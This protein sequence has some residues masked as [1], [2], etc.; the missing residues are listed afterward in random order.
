M[1]V[2]KKSLAAFMAFLF[3]LSCMSVC[4]F[5]DDTTALKSITMESRSDSAISFAIDGFDVE[6]DTVKVVFIKE[7][8]KGSVN[9]STVSAATTNPVV[10]STSSVST[11]SE[12]IIYA[13]KNMSGDPSDYSYASSA[14]FKFY[15]DAPVIVET[16][17]SQIKVKAVDGC[18]YAI[19]DMTTNTLS[20]YQNSPVFTALTPGGKYQIYIRFAADAKNSKIGASAAV[21]SET[22]TTRLASPDKPAKPVL[23]SYTMNSI[24]VKEV[25]GVEFT[26]DGGKNWQTDGT[27]DDLKKNTTYTI[28]ARGVFDPKTQLE[29][30]HSAS[31]IVK[32]ASR[33]VYEAEIDDC[34]VTLSA[35]EIKFGD[36]FT[37]TATGDASD[38]AE[39]L[40]GDT[41]YIPVSYEIFASSGNSVYDDDFY[42]NNK[43]NT[44]HTN[45]TE[46]LNIRLSVGEY[47]LKVYFSVEQYYDGEWHEINTDEAE[48]D[49]EIYEPSTTTEILTYL[50]VILKLIIKAFSTIFGFIGGFL[51]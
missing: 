33:N 13:R 44:S 47:E 37:I 24:D 45:V 1:T 12:Y 35:S 14:P 25:A 38:S 23:V 34:E 36:K 17:D 20:A 29:G 5:A 43:K 9:W 48:V 3:V 46:E 26:I 21:S 30:E 40:N 39:T 2:M 6:E 10:F 18:E 28:V 7:S 31:L 42:V 15:P 32:T 11:S 22:I 41:R 49:F 8:E 50:N 51:S 27:F 16:T 4:A 19:K